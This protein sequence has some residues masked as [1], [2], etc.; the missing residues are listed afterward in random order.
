MLLDRSITVRSLITFSVARTRVD[1]PSTFRKACLGV[2]SGV[3]AETAGLLYPP[4]VPA[5]M[6]ERRRR[7]F[8]IAINGDQRRRRQ[9][10]TNNHLLTDLKLSATGS[11]SIEGLDLELGGLSSENSSGGGCRMVELKST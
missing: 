9:T 8:C 4:E 5:S 3:T 1:L 11:V 2:D 7:R 10:S 6:F